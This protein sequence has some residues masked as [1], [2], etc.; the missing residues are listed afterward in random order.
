[1]KL[2]KENQFFE[3]TKKCEYEL[4]NKDFIV[5]RKDKKFCCRECKDKK[6][7]R[8]VYYFKKGGEYI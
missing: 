1:M 6:R 7:L 8:K 3:T 2:I 4:C 5:T